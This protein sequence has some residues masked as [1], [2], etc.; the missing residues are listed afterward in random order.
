MSI[1]FIIPA[2]NEET[3]IE[4]TY[5]NL[6]KAIQR[7]KLKDF[8]I[9]FINDGSTDNSLKII[10][11]IS[12][13]NS[14]VFVI[15]NKKNLGLSLSIF[16]AIKKSKKKF[17]WWLP[18]DDNLKHKEI[19]KMI[20][21]YSKIDFILTKHQMNR[22]FLRV[23]VSNGFTTLVNILFFL[24]CHITIPF[25]SKKKLIKK[26]NKIKKSVLDAELTIKLLRQVI[27]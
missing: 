11:K 15:D 3:N 8:E 27:I 5:K 18:S 10:K 4:N 19:S 9:I 24:K 1:S 14:K 22:T 25:F 21:N 7:V 2:F 17:I 13:K 26:K 23:F 20:S 6:I 12:K 16:K